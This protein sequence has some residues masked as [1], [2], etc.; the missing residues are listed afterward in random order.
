M[1]R[2]ERRA[3]ILAAAR[4][5]FLA[6]GYHAAAM[7]D[8]ADEAGVGKPVLYQHFPGKLELYTALLEVLGDHLVQAVVAALEDVTSGAEDRVRAA[9]RAYLDFV[10]GNDT[11]GQLLLDS[12][13]RGDTAVQEIL[14]RVER[15]VADLVVDA[16][17]TVESLGEEE[18]VLFGGML[19]GGI[20]AAVRLWRDGDSP[21]FD[22]REIERFLARVASRAVTGSPAPVSQRAAVL[23]LDRRYAAARAAGPHLVQQPMPVEPA[24]VRPVP[25]SIYLEPGTNAGEV[26]RATLAVLDVFGIEVTDERPPVIGS[27]F[28]VML[29]RTK[30]ALTSAEMADVMTRLERAIEMPVLHKPQAEIDAAR[31]D[32]V[33]KLITA[34]GSERNACI[35][36]GSVFLLKVDGAIVSRNLSQRD[37]AFLERNSRLL[38]SPRE[39][40]AALDELA[41][42]VRRAD[43]VVVEDGAA[44]VTVRR[45]DDRGCVGIAVTVDGGPTSSYEVSF[46]QRNGRVPLSAG[47]VHVQASSDGKAV[48]RE[49]ELTITVKRLTD[50]AGEIELVLASRD[51]RATSYALDFA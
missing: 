40:L 8:V 33:A 22:R 31:A 10:T 34:L 7:G 4:R 24:A 51:G 6:S 43:Q 48:L 44:R 11:A 26:H 17:A 35:Q 19:T 29:G 38:G 36:A 21:S 18:R 16:V 37:L 32:A 28:K 30:K 27:W 47:V 14:G 45:P 5:V 25:V 39:V 1:P 42:E 23:E 41:A 49:R 13:L 3:Q 12:G 46:G 9:V 20:E 2:A 50:S 15:E